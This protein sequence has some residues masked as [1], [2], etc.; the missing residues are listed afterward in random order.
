MFG[1]EDASDNY[2]FVE[3]VRQIHVIITG[4]DLKIYKKGS[5]K[6]SDYF[7]D[8]RED[9]SPRELLNGMNS[10]IDITYPNAA[11]RNLVAARRGS[12]RLRKVEWTENFSE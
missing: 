12:G 6:P 10:F 9:A 2:V 7:P 3:A 11:A 4:L 8:S 1:G 5:G